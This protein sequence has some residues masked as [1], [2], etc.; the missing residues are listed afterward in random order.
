MLVR[1]LA[2]NLKLVGV[3]LI[4]AEVLVLDLVLPLSQNLGNHVIDGLVDNVLM[5][6]LRSSIRPTGSF[7]VFA[8]SLK[9]VGVELVL[10]LL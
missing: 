10:D 8:L 4:S 2:L 7:T 9:L 6:K 5:V 3:E 1:V